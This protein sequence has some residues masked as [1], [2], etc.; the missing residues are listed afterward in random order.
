MFVST[1]PEP[2][3]NKCIHTSILPQTN[4]GNRIGYLSCV[5]DKEITVRNFFWNVLFTTCLKR[6]IRSQPESASAFGRTCLWND[7]NVHIHSHLRQF[8]ELKLLS[9]NA[10]RGQHCP[11]FNGSIEVAD[12]CELVPDLL[13]PIQDFFATVV[14]T[15]GRFLAHI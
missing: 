15:S 8:H 14:T 6:R 7:V 1:C 13:T 5:N 9:L 2:L 3:P 4:S 10:R 12:G 11:R